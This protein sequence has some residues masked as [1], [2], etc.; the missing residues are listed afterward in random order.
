[1]H[2]S[3][4][5]PVICLMGTTATGKTDA[6]AFLSEHLPVEIVSVDSSLVYQDMNIG[7]AKPDTDFLAKYPHHLVDIRHPNDT[8]S[9]ADFYGDAIEIIQQITSRGNIP[10]LAGGTMF[11]FNA[12]ESGLSELPAAN[13]EIREQIEKEAQELGW[14]VLHQK[15]HNLDKE[16]AGRI[17]K[18]DAQRIQRALEMVLQSG[19]T[20]AELSADKKPAL[21]NP[22]V[23]IALAFSNRRFL[24]ERIEKRFDIMLEQGLVTEVK[25]LLDNGV[26]KDTPSMKMIG[27][28]QVLDYLDN[29]TTYQQMRSKGVSATRQL[30]KRQLTWLRNQPAVNWWVDEGLIDKEFSKLLHF[31][32]QQLAYFGL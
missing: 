27:Y 16:S 21:A 5:P 32:N 24:H 12:L 11:Y 4:L 25:R 26:H 20:I 29:V 7:T 17:D 28:R 31:I 1:M 10:V 22:I 13:A 9:V 18:H 3:S 15:L 2:S 30:A 14:P 8:Y 19:K 23:K 6:A